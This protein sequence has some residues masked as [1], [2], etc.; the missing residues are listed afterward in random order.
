MARIMG[1]DPLSQSTG[2]SSL[3]GYDTGTAARAPASDV[4][5]I[6]GD[7]G[8]GATT[9]EKW[10][11]E[12]ALANQQ[13]QLTQFS[14][15]KQQADIANAMA[16]AAAKREADMFGSQVAQINLA[17]Q[18]AQQQYALNKAAEERAAREFYLKTE[19]PYQVQRGADLAGAAYD[20]WRGGIGVPISQESQRQYAAYQ[21]AGSPTTGYGSTFVDPAARLVGSTEMHHR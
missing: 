2:T 20:K 12:L 6:T 16:Q 1:Q 19:L 9:A 17:N 13:Q 8:I 11:H 3:L 7:P 10:A 15:Q 4:I 21:A 5:T 14:W 18:L